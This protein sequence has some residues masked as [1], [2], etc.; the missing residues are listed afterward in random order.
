MLLATHA[1]ALQ[2][3]VEVSRQVLPDHHVEMPAIAEPPMYL[4]RAWATPAEDPQ[5]GGE[6]ELQDGRD[7]PRQR[8]LTANLVAA[9]ETE[10][11]ILLAD[12]PAFRALKRSGAYRG[13]A[14]TRF[15]Q[16]SLSAGATQVNLA[17]RLLVTPT[18]LHRTSRCSLCGLVVYDETE[19]LTH[20]YNCPALQGLR[21]SRHNRVRDVLADLLRRIGGPHS[22]STEAD[23]GSARFDI[24]FTQ[25]L[26]T[27]Y[28]DV[29]V[30]NPASASYV[31]AAADTDDAAAQQRALEKRHRYGD[32]LASHG[33]DPGALLPFVIETTGRLGPEARSLLDELQSTFAANSPTRNAAATIAF[34]RD[35][36]KYVLYEDNSALVHQAWSRLL[37]LQLP[38][39]LPFD[40]VVAG[41]PE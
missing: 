10:L 31:S 16:H 34:F 20:G 2:P 1:Q 21:T 40:A 11:D 19:C 36:M 28:I 33:I 9:Y 24:R 15:R 3:V 41:G 39:V 38:T 30:V 14:S 23:L 35:R 22:V 27:R 6:E 37:P 8:T 29:S 18:P 12:A 25:G 13:S 4:P 5:A 7:C 26:T 32:L 17:S